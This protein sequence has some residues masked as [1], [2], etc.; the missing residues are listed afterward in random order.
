MPSGLSLAANGLRFVPAETWFE[1]G[2]PATWTFEIIDDNG[3]IVT[4]FE[5]SH[6]ELAHLILVRRDLTEFQHLHP[7][8]ETDGTW[9]IENLEFSEPGVYRVFV[10]IVVDSRPTTLGHDVFVPG[11]MPAKTRPAASRQA[12]SQNYRIELR[13]DEIAAGEHTQLMFDI[14]DDDER[15]PQ[16][17]PYLGAFGHL[18]ALRDGDL[19]YLHIHPEE[20]DPESGRVEFGAQ[21]PTPGRYRLFLQAK[22]DGNLITSSF[23][24]EIDR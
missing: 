18:V 24:I 16:L 8:L 20:T 13:T 15:V 22:P 14:R 17:K 5:D 2:V 3:D 12:Q 19:A 10:D 23:D 6:G 9:R 7:T 1:L 11:E 21:F 4:V